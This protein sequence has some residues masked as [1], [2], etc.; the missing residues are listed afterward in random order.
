MHF[1]GNVPPLENWTTLMAV[2]AKHKDGSTP[3]QGHQS[4]PGCV[5]EYDTLSEIIARSSE[6][7]KV[8]LL[9]SVDSSKERGGH[10]ARVTLNPHCVVGQRCAETVAEA[11]WADRP[12]RIRRVREAS[13][14]KQAL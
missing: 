7:G 1:F 2:G 11:G 6:S 14:T 12:P 8:L 10:H 5:S 4:T 13:G 3:P 9:A